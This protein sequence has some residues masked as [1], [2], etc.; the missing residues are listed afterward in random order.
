MIATTAHASWY[1]FNSDN[2]C[3]SI[4]E[5]KPS[6]ED[7]A[8]RNEYAVESD[9]LLPVD[10][11]EYKNGKIQ[12]IKKSAEDLAIEVRKEARRQEK[13]EIE[14]RMEKIAYEQLKAEGTIFKEVKDKD[15][16]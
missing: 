1:I 3:I 4:A 13:L 10:E 11:T 9:V 15:F 14:K 7:M 12:I 8:T 5:Y 16:E 6:L 2:K